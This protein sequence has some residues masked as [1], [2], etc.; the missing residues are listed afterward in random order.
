MRFPSASTRQATP[1]KQEWS[2]EKGV[3]VMSPTRNS[4]PDRS[5]PVAVERRPPPEDGRSKHHLARAR[6]G[7]DRDV[8]PDEVQKARVVGMGVGEEDRVDVRTL[9]TFGE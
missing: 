2:T 6:R 1:P 5:G 7:I 8:R 4:G 3:T 9:R